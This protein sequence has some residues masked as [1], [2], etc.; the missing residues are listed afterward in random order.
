VHLTLLSLSPAP[1]PRTHT[2]A[3]PLPRSAG[4]ECAVPGVLCLS[5]CPHTPT[6]HTLCVFLCVGRLLFTTCSHPLSTLSRTAVTDPPV[7]PARYASWPWSWWRRQEAAGEGPWC[8]CWRWLCWC[9]GCGI[10]CQGVCTRSVC[11]CGVWRGFMFACTRGVCVPVW[12]VCM[13]ACVHV[14]LASRGLGYKGGGA[15][16]WSILPLH[17][18]ACGGTFPSSP[19]VTAS[20]HCL[21]PLTGCEGPW[22]CWWCRC[23]RRRREGRWSRCWQGRQR[24]GWEAQRGWR[25]RWWWCQAAQLGWQ[26]EAPLHRF[27]STPHSCVLLV[28]VR[29]GGGG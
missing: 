15:R 29:T 21:L 6:K 27:V 8:H 19:C 24:G 22:W 9:R 13:H 14:G 12:C 5:F 2:V 17:V 25:R 20:C 18:C 4:S 26:C 3:P 28:A 1:H 7:L 11:L 10:G 16:L 23:R